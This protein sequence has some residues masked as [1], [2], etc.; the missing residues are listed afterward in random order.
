MGLNRIRSLLGASEE[1]VTYDQVADLVS[2]Q[3]EEDIDLDFKRALYE[4]RGSN[5]REFAKDIAAFANT[6]GGLIV[7]GIDE[8]DAGG[9]ANELVPVAF[10]TEAELERRLADAVA[11]YSAP[12]AL[13]RV[14]R[15]PS[16]GDP[17]K[18]FVLIFVPKS[19]L[20]PH[21]I[22]DEERLRFVVRE[23]RQ[24][25]NLAEHEVATLYRERFTR[26]SDI[27]ARSAVIVRDA[28]AAWRRS[29]QLFIDG[30]LV[31]EQAG[32]RPVDG[33]LIRQFQDELSR[34]P[35]GHPL[36][37]AVEVAAGHRRVRVRPRPQVNR[38]VA[39]EFH[40]DGSGY[41]GCE[42]QTRAISSFVVLRQ[43]DVL[44]RVEQIFTTLEKHAAASGVDG[45]LKARFELAQWGGELSSRTRLIRS[46]HSDD[47]DDTHEP[48]GP[49]VSEF[50]FP[51]L[52]ATPHERLLAIRAVLSDIF[53]SFGVPDVHFISREGMLVLSE[54]QKIFESQELSAFLN[55]AWMSSL[56]DKR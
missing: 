38:P 28:R 1:E 37:N 9:V 31:P 27:D 13:F 48:I 22:R 17:N 33:S 4:L 19:T 40:A 7:I 41:F 12:R 6:R 14:R 52:W 45:D 10:P 49:I 20:A 34:L 21:A 51:L 24:A 16:P 39:A 44:N 42:L 26:L 11:N 29:P 43:A 46:I 32:S 23:Q 5:A 55:H 18:G 3:I 35:R 56:I 36:S 30:V 54:L 53:Q 8:T 15:V 50:T 47:F 25:R 2:R